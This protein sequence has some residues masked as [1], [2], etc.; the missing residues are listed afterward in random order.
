MF[1]DLCSVFQAGAVDNGPGLNFG[2]KAAQNRP[3][4]KITFEFLNISL[5]QAINLEIVCE[6][7][8]RRR[9]APL[10]AYVRPHMCI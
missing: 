6:G 3:R 10:G 5:S 4:I 2:R 9:S 7:R 1:F 8:E